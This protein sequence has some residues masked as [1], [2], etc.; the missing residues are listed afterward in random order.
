[1]GTLQEYEVVVWASPDYS[2]SY[3]NIGAQE[4]ISDYLGLGGHLLISGQDIAIVEDWEQSTYWFRTQLGARYLGEAAPPYT[5]TGD[6]E[7]FFAG[8]EFSL[9]GTDS[10]GNQDSP[11]IVSIRP[12]RLARPL[13]R[14]ADGAIGAV[15]SGE[16]QPHSVVYL[17]FG[18]EGVTGR[19]NRAEVVSRAMVQFSQQPPEAAVDFLRAPIEDFVAPQETRRYELPIVNLSETLTDTFIISVGENSW[20]A[21]I[22]TPTLTVGP[23]RLAHTELILQVPAA[24]PRG[25]TETFTI[26]IRSA[27]NSLIS[28]TLAVSLRTTGG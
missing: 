26:Q 15:G 25:I 18:L 7:S 14:Y 28:T 11:E 24:L 16:C 21:T 9:N 13:F 17:G 5:L 8:L 6:T 4:V 2:P 12:E 19:S 3:A 10:E 23:C 1:M 22:V 27:T 20:P